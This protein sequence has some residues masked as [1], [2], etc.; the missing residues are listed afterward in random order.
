MYLCSYD[1]EKVKKN[2][3][4]QFINSLFGEIKSKT[5]EGTSQRLEGTNH[6]L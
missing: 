1:I 3:S 2:L 4:G 6:N 5:E